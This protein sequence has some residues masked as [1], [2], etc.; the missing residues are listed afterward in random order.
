MTHSAKAPTVRLLTFDA[1]LPYPEALALQRGIA[2]EIRKGD[3]PDTLLLLQHP[4][5]VTLGRNG[6]PAGVLSAPKVLERAGIGLHRVERGGQATYHGPGQL[7]GYPIVK[8]KGWKIGVH[9]YVRGLEEVMIRT[10]AAF[11]VEA[12]RYEGRPG[13]YCKDDG[14]LHKL[15]A[16][17]VAVRAGVS[18][19]GF[20][21]NV[22]PD[23]SHYR[24][25][26]PCGH[27]DTPPTSL[28][29]QSGETVSVARVFPTATEAFS[30][31]FGVILLDE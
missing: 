23:L 24:H 25:I 18:L 13:V 12:F 30:T 10:A 26:L 14:V 21:L 6:D 1:P 27:A 20:A 17:G 9:A 28:S 11:G 22:D 8:L 29:Q 19:H 31:V 15:G 4:P 5:V 7:V 2:A 3:A 16:L